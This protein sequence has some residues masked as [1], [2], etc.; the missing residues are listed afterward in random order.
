MDKWKGFFNDDENDSEDD[1]DGI[2][3]VFEVKYSGSHAGPWKPADDRRATFCPRTVL[4]SIPH[5]ACDKYIII[6]GNL[7]D[8]RTGMGGK[9]FIVNR[10]RKV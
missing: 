5:A 8:G 7:W 3:D 4:Q 10:M 1:D 9:N 6:I 2:P